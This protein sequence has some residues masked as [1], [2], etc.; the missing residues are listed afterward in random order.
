[1]EP[2]LAA[3]GGICKVLHYQKGQV[4]YA[5]GEPAPDVRCVRTGTVKLS[6]LSP[7]GKEGVVAMLSEGDF[8]GEG[9]MAGQPVRMATATAATAASVMLIAKG[10]MDR[11]L[12][13]EPAFASRFLS[14]MLASNIRIEADLVDHLFSSTEKRLARALLVLSR[15]GQEQPTQALPDISQQTRA[16]MIG[17]TRSRVSFYMN[18]F[19]KL[20]FVDYNGTLK[21]NGDLLSAAYSLTE[22]EPISQVPLGER[23]A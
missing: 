4:I 6:V 9:V 3:A 2:Y 21:V 13:E 18:K 22:R 17:V 10:M 5:Q 15:H 16:E 23:S 19:R 14:H 7:L 12:R 8:F 20:G 11:L 1:M